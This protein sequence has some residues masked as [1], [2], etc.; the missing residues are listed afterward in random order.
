MFTDIVGSTDM[1]SRLG[2]VRSVE[3]V[4]AHDS[5]VRRCLKDVGGW[6]VKHTGDGIMASFGDMDSAVGCACSI[7][8]ELDTFNR[9]NT[10]Q[11]Q[12]RIGIHAGEPIED[13]NDLFGATVQ[14]AARICAKAAGESV[15]ISD[16]VRDDLKS[17]FE[18]AELGSHPLKGIS[19]PAPLF[20]VVWRRA[21]T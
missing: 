1:T 4:R 11:L 6:E 17:D 13:N 21:V 2:D 9:S 12:V 8:R 20:K 3:M 14:T 5:I 19:K 10:E 7:Q 15:M 16:V 18:L